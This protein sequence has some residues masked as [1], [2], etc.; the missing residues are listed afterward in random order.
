[1]FDEFVKY[2]LSTF[3]FRIL[4]MPIDFPARLKATRDMRGLTQAELGKLAGLPSTTISH[5]ESGS[6]KPSFDNL[7]R[8]TRVL[9]V[10]TDYLIG[11]T[12]SPDAT[13]AATRI[14]R[15]LPDATDAEI[16]MLEAV[17]KSLANQRRPN[18]G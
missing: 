14:A 10:S 3:R 15:H 13:A 7:R 6:R 17:A 18:D 4:H 12:D 5:F 11:I 9:A 1:M 8:L 2:D 16:S